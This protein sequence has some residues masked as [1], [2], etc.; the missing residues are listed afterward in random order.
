[1]AAPLGNQNACRSNR[2]Y[3]N[4][5]L[6]TLKQYE[7]SGTPRGEALSQVTTRLVELALKG[8]PWAIKEIADRVDG[9]SSL[10]LRTETLTPDDLTLRWMT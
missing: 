4:A 10:A 1:M 8:E 9:K 2:E 3:R 6:R 5:L 7:A